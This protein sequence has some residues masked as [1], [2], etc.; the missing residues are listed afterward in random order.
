MLTR[1]TIDSLLDRRGNIRSTDGDRIGSIGQ[2]YADDAGGE[3]LWV[4]V[5]TGLFGTSESFVP[6]EG[7]WIDGDDLVVPY[8]KDQVRNAPRVDVDGH[9]E[10]SEE[11][12]IYEHYQL[13]G[14]TRTY[15]EAISGGYDDAGGTMG[16]QAPGPGTPDAATRSE[17][18]LNMAAARPR[19]RPYAAKTSSAGGEVGRERIDIGGTDGIRQ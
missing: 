6:L 14:G 16:G 10:P 13:G 12:R 4:T 18:R 19:L 9:L 3:P 1:D 17:G 8:S 2:V 5:R 11:E 7:A 15:T